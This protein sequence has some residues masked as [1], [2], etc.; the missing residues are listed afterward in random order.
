ML[1]L[2]LLEAAEGEKE[3]EEEKVYDYNGDVERGKA[4]YCLS[5]MLPANVQCTC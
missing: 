2:E 4:T 5:S 3:E 1:P